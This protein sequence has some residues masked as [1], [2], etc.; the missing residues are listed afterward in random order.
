LRLPSHVPQAR[1]RCHHAETYVIAVA[2]RGLRHLVLQVRFA[3]SD[4]SLFVSFPYFHDSNGLISHVTWPPNL[5]P[6]TDLSLI[7][8]G[9]VTSHLVK[10]S[11]HPDGMALFTQDGRVRSVVRKQAVPLKAASGHLFTVQIQG[12]SGF[13]RAAR[14]KD[15]PKVSPTRTVLDFDFR[16]N[17][18]QAIK[19][20]GSWYSHAQLRAS[21]TGQPPNGVLGP[22]AMV[23]SPKGGI[24]LAY[25][26]SP[27]SGSPLQGYVL[28][29]TCEAIPLLDKSGG[30][31]LTM[32]A[33]FDHP[34]VVNDSSRETSVLALLYPVESYT[35]LASLIG[36]ADFRRE[37]KPI[38]TS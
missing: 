1:I 4:G 7:P 15:Q 26:L 20:V 23:Q 16:E 14:P 36:T 18:P 6:P 11:H 30:S 12:L 32:M 8:G 17:E 13:R 10:Y 31:A 9:K 5:Q 19:F 34:S 22:I 38:L 2:S 37:A 25:L 27:A 28:L 33:G 3:R 29:L 21:I 35:E 24:H